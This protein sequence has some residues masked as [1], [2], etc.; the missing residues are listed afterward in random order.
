MLREPQ[1]A[2]VDRAA[3]ALARVVREGVTSVLRHS[4]ATEVTLTT[5]AEDGGIR[6]VIASDRTRRRTPVPGRG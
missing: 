5:T 2:H 3:L 4:A 1:R 6:L